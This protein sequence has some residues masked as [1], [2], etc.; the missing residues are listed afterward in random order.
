MAASGQ[1]QQAILVGEAGIGKTSLADMLAQ[2]A[3]KRDVD[4]PWALDG[5]GEGAL[6]YWLWF[7]L[8]RALAER[9][10]AHTVESWLG[11]RASWVTHF[12]PEIAAAA[13]SEPEQNLL[14]RSNRRS[15]ASRCSIR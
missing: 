11:R 8:L 1:G 7:Q 12:L 2:H 4:V 3:R 13:P 9:R 10:G 6:V 14:R 15:S 5:D